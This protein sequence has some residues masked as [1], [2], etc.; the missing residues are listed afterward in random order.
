MFCF[1]ALDIYILASTFDKQTKKATYYLLDKDARQV[2]E[3][4]NQQG[5]KP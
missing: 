5:S 4:I 1:S 2:D 3:V